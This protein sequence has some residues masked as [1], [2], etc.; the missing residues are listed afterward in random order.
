MIKLNGKEYPI[1]KL[2]CFLP[3]SIIAKLKW[4]K[5][6]TKSK[7]QTE[8]LAACITHTH[9]QLSDFDNYLKNKDKEG[10]IEC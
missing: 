10:D 6:F 2:E 1:S 9:N 5:E 7:N 4:I 3:D 8:A